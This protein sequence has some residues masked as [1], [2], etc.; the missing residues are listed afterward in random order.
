MLRH[1]GAYYLRNPGYSGDEVDL[2]SDDWDLLGSTMSESIEALPDVL[3]NRAIRYVEYQQI[4]S[5][6]LKGMTPH[7][8]SEIMTFPFQ[9]RQSYDDLRAQYGD[10]PNPEQL[11]LLTDF[12]NSYQMLSGAL[13]ELLVKIRNQ[14]KEE[15]TL[16]AD[17]SSLTA[18]LSDAQANT[19]ASIRLL[20]GFERKWD[21]LMNPKVG[22]SLM[23]TRKQLFKPMKQTEINYVST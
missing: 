6:V 7:I 19:R 9:W 2:T 20:E 4:L 11:E 14:L 16:G 21:A 3:V 8:L 10:N 17:S 5:A 22:A 18:L 12:R 1:D 13:S 23:E 15:E